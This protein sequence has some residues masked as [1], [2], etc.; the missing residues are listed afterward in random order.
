LSETFREVFKK[1]STPEHN[2]AEELSLQD[3]AEVKG[4]KVSHD[5]E[6]EGDTHPEIRKR[7]LLT[8]T[9]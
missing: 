9:Q 1:T 3:G 4:K 5:E 2:M 8:D 7:T 6:V